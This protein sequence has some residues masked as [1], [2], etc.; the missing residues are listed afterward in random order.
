MDE[1]PNLGDELT[2]GL[3][4]RKRDSPDDLALQM[5]V[6]GPIRGE[7]R[8]DI[9]MPEVLAPGFD[10]F[11]CPANRVRGCASRNEAGNKAALPLRTRP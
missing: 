7:G 10:F 3:D 11:R 2:I 9:L 4:R 8:R 5:R 6:D 1:R